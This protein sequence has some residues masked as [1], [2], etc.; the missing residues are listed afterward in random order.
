MACHRAQRCGGEAS[1]RPGP[2]PGGAGAGLRRASRAIPARLPSG[3]RTTRPDR[4]PTPG[5]SPGCGRSASQ[6]QFVGQNACCGQMGQ[7]GQRRLQAGS[8]WSSSS[9]LETGTLPARPNPRASV[10]RRQGQAPPQP[11]RRTKIAG[12][13]SGCRCPLSRTRA[14]SRRWFAPSRPSSLKL[15][16]RQPAAVQAE[17]SPRRGADIGSSPPS[18]MNGRHLWRPLQ[19]GAAEGRPGQTSRSWGLRSA[20]AARSAAHQ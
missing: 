13:G 3:P 9:S 1:H 20:P 4:A 8:A 17:V 7:R 12:P 5:W 15:V 19:D 18:T 2:A 14:N 16:D 11:R 10:R 6:A